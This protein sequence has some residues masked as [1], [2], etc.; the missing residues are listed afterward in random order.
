MANKYSICFAFFTPRKQIKLEHTY[1]TMCFYL[2]VI[3][4]S[5][6]L[7]LNMREAVV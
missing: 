5:L 6:S 1:V 2:F 4:A 7:V 3:F